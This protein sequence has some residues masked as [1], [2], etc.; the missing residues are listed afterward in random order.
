MPASK[1]ILVIS[2]NL[3]L[4]QGL[5]T[6]VNGLSL[7]DTVFEYRC[8]GVSLKRLKPNLCI[9]LESV[10][11][12]KDR[13]WIVASYDLVISLHCKQ[14]FPTEMVRGIKCINV[15]PGLN[16]YNR[17][18]FP[19]VFSIL[20]GLPTGATIHE[21][22]EQLDHGPIIAQCEVPNHNWDTSADIYGRI[23]TAE[24]QLLRENLEA[25]VSGEYESNAPPQE[26]NVNLKKDFMELC[27]LDP[28]KAQTVKETIDLLRALTHGD[29]RNAHYIDPETGRKV[30][31]SVVL[32]SDPE[33]G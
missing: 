8:S 1:R 9:P 16:P 5:V 10:D 25:I 7:S 26:G 14:F 13:K 31:V 22:D 12:K 33:N 20:N 11:V 15:H 24:L 28:D 4:I 6:I 3:V 17:G 19:Q 32:K 27:K 29:H 23:V 21:I 2:D 30:Y 18:W